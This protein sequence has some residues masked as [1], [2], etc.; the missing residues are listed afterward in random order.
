MLSKSLRWLFLSSWQSLNEVAVPCILAKSEKVA[1]PSIL[2]KSGRDGCTCHVSRAWKR[3][4]FASCWCS[5]EEV[6]VPIML[7]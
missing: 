4:L 6:A 1:V 5:L 2:D 7:A 3:L